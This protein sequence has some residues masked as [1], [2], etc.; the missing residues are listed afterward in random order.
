MTTKEQME[1]WRNQ[2]MKSNE[3]LLILKNIKRE[4]NIQPSEKVLDK[5]IK[6]HEEELEEAK[7]AYNYYLEEE[8]K[9]EDLI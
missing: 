1:Y 7:E 5:Y 6:I 4:M 8:I 9:N 3:I 2:K